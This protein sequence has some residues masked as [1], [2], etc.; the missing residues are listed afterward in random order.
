VYLY[1]MILLPVDEW[2]AAMS[3]AQ[4]DQS[5]QLQLDGISS[6]ALG[7]VAQEIAGPSV[8]VP[9]PGTI[10]DVWELRINRDA[11]IAV[12]RSDQRLWFFAARAGTARL[13]DHEITM[14]AQL[15]RQQRY[16]SMRGDR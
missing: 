9:P 10:L 11:P 12:P 14:S 5:N 3:S 4:I 1:D 15:F 2:A 16:L 7:A 13:S 6:P 8:F